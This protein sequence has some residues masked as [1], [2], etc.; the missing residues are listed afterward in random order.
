MAAVVEF[1]GGGDPTVEHRLDEIHEI[2]RTAREEL[3]PLTAAE[4]L[5]GPGAGAAAGVGAG[6]ACAA[7]CSLQ[8]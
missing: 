6:S 3:V 5:A 4:A 1:V 7:A 2:L 8:R